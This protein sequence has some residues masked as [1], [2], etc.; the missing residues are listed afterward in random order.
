[1]RAILTTTAGQRGPA[2]TVSSL[3][4]GLAP[5]ETFSDGHLVSASTWGP[6]GAH[7]GTHVVLPTLA[8]ISNHRHSSQSMMEQSDNQIHYL[9]KRKR[10]HCH[11]LSQRKLF[12]FC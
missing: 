4:L 2:H 5:M 9:E 1:M 6:W 11:P 8:V 12:P 3:F 10:T 7:T